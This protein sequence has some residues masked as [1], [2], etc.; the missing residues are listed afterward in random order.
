MRLIYQAKRVVTGQCYIGQA[1]GVKAIAQDWRRICH[2]AHF[3]NSRLH[4]AIRKF[5]PNSFQLSV[6]DTCHSDCEELIA[7]YVEERGGAIGYNRRNL[8]LAKAQLLRHRDHRLEAYNIQLQE[9]LG[10]PVPKPH[11]K[12]RSFRSMTL[13]TI[14]LIL[15]LV[16][17]GHN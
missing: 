15:A 2:Q 12:S 13:I 16:K 4:Q 11:P 6:I 14:I 5:G 7:S 1:D 9:V 17:H 10:R 8:D 3:E